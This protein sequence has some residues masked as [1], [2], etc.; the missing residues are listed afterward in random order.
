MPAFG[1]VETGEALGEV[2]AAV[3]FLDDFADFRA[4]RAVSFPV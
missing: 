2:A 3:E 4:E 1:A